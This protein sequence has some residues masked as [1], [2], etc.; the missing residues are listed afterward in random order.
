MQV[1]NR[2]LLG[3]IADTLTG[4]GK[5]A[6]TNP[7][8][9]ALTATT[10][11]E[12]TMAKP[13]SYYT[14][15]EA[16]F[17]NRKGEEVKDYA[18]HLENELMGIEYKPMPTVPAKTKNI[19][20]D[21]LKNLASILDLGLTEQVSTIIAKDRGFRE[22][23]ET[24]S[25]QKIL[26]LDFLQFVKEE[27]G[28]IPAKAKG[29]VAGTGAP[30]AKSDSSIRALVSML[31]GTPLVSPEE[32]LEQLRALV[33]DPDRTARAVEALEAKAMENGRD[34]KGYILLRVRSKSP[35]KIKS[36]R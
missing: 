15:K 25:D 14:V 1:E 4:N 8:P 3:A 2:S 5:R 6:K 7:H 33:G 9:V 17:R 31:S 27:V 35:A 21:G 32:A 10:S 12:E 18:L 36:K 34:S 30:K 13:Q 26:T 22:L 29:R 23:V 20:L 24:L 28:K 11:T 19:R 16:T